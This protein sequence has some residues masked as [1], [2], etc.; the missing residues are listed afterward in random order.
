MAGETRAHRQIG[1]LI[2]AAAA[3]RRTA[4]VM[5]SL[6]QWAATDDNKRDD[7]ARSDEVPIG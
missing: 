4:F 5:P 6:T 1:R 3:E 7:H 2:A